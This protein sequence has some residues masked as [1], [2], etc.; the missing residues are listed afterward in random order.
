MTGIRFDCP[1]CEA[2]VRIAP[3]AL[4]LAVVDRETSWYAYRCPECRTIVDDAAAPPV[5]AMLAWVGCTATRARTNGP[6]GR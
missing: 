5:V 2:A 4:L 6:A 3:R 1:Q